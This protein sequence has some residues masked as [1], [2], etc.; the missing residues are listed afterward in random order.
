[1]LQPRPE[2]II[3]SGQQEGERAVLMD[4]IAFLGR[5][6]DCTV[7]IRDPHVSRQQLKFQLAPGGW[8]AENLTTTLVRINGKKFKQ[9]SKAFLETGDILGVG[10][11]TYILFVSPDDDPEAALAAYRQANPQAEVPAPGAESSDQA[12]VQAEGATQP[13]PPPEPSKV[14]PP[15]RV[16]PAAPPAPVPLV[17]AQEEE[18]TKPPTAEDMLAEERRNKLKKYG[19]MFGIYVM[20]LLGGVIV[21]S[22]FVHRGERD[23]SP[24]GLP[25]T[26]T[27]MEIQEVLSERLPSRG[28]LPARAEA[29]LAQAR[30]L[31][32]E[33]KKSGNRYLCVQYYNLYL[34]Y[35]G[36]RGTGTLSYE[37]ERNRD[38]A[39]AELIENVFEH[40][41]MGI[42]YRNDRNWDAAEDEFEN[43]QRRVPAPYFEPAP[44]ADNLIFKNVQENLN[45]I[46]AERNRRRR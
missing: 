34:A 2:L 27:K 11:E 22:K 45:Y 41:G 18:E 3:V 10:A 21:L 43:V 15:T 40:Y 42:V 19:V 46:N 37:D 6:S 32:I 4:N 12:P 20:V 7:Q 26:L 13:L 36:F 25:R 33:R 44:N 35:G 38:T 16:P 31:Y 30:R 1:M 28:D 9:G 23:V 29:N 17:E 39:L 24:A 8:V 5:S 14:G